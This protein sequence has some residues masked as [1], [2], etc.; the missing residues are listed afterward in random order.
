MHEDKRWKSTQKL[1]VPTVPKAPL[2]EETARWS[3]LNKVLS[4]VSH[5]PETQATVV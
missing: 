5:H 1:E 3:L 2:E 4:A